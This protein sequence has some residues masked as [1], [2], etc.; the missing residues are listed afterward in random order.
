MDQG[1]DIISGHEDKLE[2]LEYSIKDK[3]KL[4][5]VCE[6]NLCNIENTMNRQKSMN[7][8]KGNINISGNEMEKIKKRQLGQFEKKL[9]KIDI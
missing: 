3:D 7:F 6:Q 8:Q 9:V 2:D 5:N 4:T 1:E